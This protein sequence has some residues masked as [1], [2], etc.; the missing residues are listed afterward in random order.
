MD[1]DSWAQDNRRI[2]VCLSSSVS[3]LS[4][5]ICS[6][7]STHSPPAYSCI[8]HKEKMALCGKAA[9]GPLEIL[10]CIGPVKVIS[11]L[12]AAWSWLVFTDSYLSFQ[13]SLVT[14]SGDGQY[15]VATIQLHVNQLVGCSLWILVPR[16]CTNRNVKT[17]M[18]FRRCFNG[19]S[20]SPLVIPRASTLMWLRNIVKMILDWT[21][22]HSSAA[23]QTVAFFTGK[24]SLLRTTI[25][26]CGSCRKTSWWYPEVNQCPPIF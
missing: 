12:K 11:D 22:G 8:L 14:C 17:T 21:P 6:A 25:R 20:S 2:L 10:L 4:A 7:L 23:S 18:L 24:L 15:W 26:S 3:N 9:S 16:G 13:S 19:K 5:A 1:C